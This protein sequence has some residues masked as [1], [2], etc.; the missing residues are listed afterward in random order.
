M[1]GEAVAIQ[2][3]T[4]IPADAI[5]LRRVASTHQSFGPQYKP[6]EGIPTSPVFEPSG[7]EGLSV[8]LWLGPADMAAVLAGHEEFGVVALSVGELRAH[9]L[10][11]LRDPLPENP[12]HC[13]LFGNLGNRTL[14]RTLCKLATWE[15]YP[16]CFPDDCRRPIVSRRP[17]AET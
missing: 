11:I 7:D 8:T 2:D 10:A 5:V 17:E 9:G 6:S 13:E 14:R 16:I 3:D 4:S 1:T 15:L 12:N